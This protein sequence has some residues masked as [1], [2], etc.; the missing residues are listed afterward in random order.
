[1]AVVVVAL[2]AM[3][4][5]QEAGAAEQVPL[6]QVLLPQEQAA[7]EVRHFSQPLLG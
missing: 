6:V 1:L 2:K 7:R 5:G 3:L 4:E